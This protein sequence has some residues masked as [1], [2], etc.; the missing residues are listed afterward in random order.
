[1]ALVVSVG[2]SASMCFAHEGHNH[3]APTT[4]KAPKGGMIKALD[5]SRVEVL[6]KGSNLKIY[7]Y[8]KDMKPAASGDFKITAKAVIPRSKKTEDIKLE[9]KDVFYEGIYDAKGLH[10]YTLKLE[11]T[12]SKLGHTDDLTFNIEPR[13]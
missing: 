11:V 2:F 1:M 9:A 7:L 12:H 13:K 8:D 3:D 5:E 10:R 6:S 4:I